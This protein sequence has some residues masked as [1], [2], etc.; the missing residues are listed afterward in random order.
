MRQIRAAEVKPGMEVEWT[1]VGVT[2]KC[3]ASTVDSASP[4]YGVNL[5]TSEG[6][7][8]HIPGNAEVT[9]LAEPQPEEPT[10]FGA[11]VVVGGECYL[12][13]QQVSDD[14]IPWLGGP[15]GRWYRWRELLGQ[16]QV[17]IIDADPS[18]TVPAEAPE[19]PDR[20]EE[21]PEDDEHLRA[22]RWRD[23]KG[24][25]WSSRDGQWGYHSFTMGWVGLVGY[26]YPFDGPWVRVP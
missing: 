21:W 18:W 16:G 23:R 17:T 14:T 11:R 12:R 2:R 10:T 8:V 13:A 25:V 3:V 26:R 19:V 7:L 1:S 24:A 22:Y 9:V 20:I 4:R 6:G 5:H 15:M